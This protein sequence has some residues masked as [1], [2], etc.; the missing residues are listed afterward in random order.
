MDPAE[1]ERMRRLE[2]GHWWYRGM[3]RISRAVLDSRPATGRPGR[4]LD[5]GCGTGGF[6]AHLAEYGPV[7]GLDRHPL[8]L[9]L[10]RTRG[11][12][13]LVQGGVERLPFA[14]GAFELVACMDVLYHRDVPSDA[15]A[16]RELARILRPGGWLLLRLPA[17]EWMRRGH[18]AVVGT[19][20]RYTRGRVRELLREGGFRGV[21]CSYANAFLLPAAVLAAGLERWTPG[22]APRSDLERR[23]GPWE[24]FLERV[25][26]SEAGWIVRTGLPFGLSVVALGE[27]P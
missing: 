12:P 7:I 2:D 20:R 25:L 26:A 15:E 11:L 6:T 8:A 17:Y 5:A 22:R 1:Y 9:A 21:L 13:T 3:A 16:M 27:R 24:A 18:D 10:A 4:V 19:A 14:D 23:A